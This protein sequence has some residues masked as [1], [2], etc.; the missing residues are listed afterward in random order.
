MYGFPRKD[1]RLALRRAIDTFQ[2][3]GT[4]T[5]YPL[6][7]A[8]SPRYQA[9]V[10]TTVGGALTVLDPTSYLLLPM[11]STD[12]TTSGTTVTLTGNS[13]GSGANTVDNNLSTYT[14]ASP[15]SN[16][17][18]IYDLGS[19]KIIRGASVYPGTDGGPTLKLNAYQWAASTDNATWI[20]LYGRTSVTSFVRNYDA[21]ANATA[22][23]YWRFNASSYSGYLV[24]YEIELFEAA[25][26]G[27][28]SFV[29]FSSAP[30]A[31]TV[32]I[33]YVPM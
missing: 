4:N 20:T 15:G 5:T 19:A 29:S 9:V 17:G 22:Y 21:W 23:R 7:R 28:I 11:F 30:A 27:A 31:G 32:V 18:F 8:A 25:N 6:L 33:E 3:D 12:I 13:Y 14:N 10:R 1:K 2:A 16:S 24:M 26:D